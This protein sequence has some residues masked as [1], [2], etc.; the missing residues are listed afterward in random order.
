MMLET[1]LIVMPN[2]VGE[3]N[4]SD[5]EVVTIK[6]VVMDAPIDKRRADGYWISGWGQSA[7]TINWQCFLEQTP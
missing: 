6:V 3:V 2:T 5:C 1:Q 7:S 4:R